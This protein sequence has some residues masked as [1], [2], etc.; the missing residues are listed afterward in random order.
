[1]VNHP[2]M[3]GKFGTIT[4]ITANGNLIGTWGGLSISLE[5]DKIKVI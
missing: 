2:E 1:M 5:N 3:T 4:Q